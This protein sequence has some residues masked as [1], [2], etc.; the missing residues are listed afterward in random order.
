VRATASWP[1]L[2]IS[3]RLTGKERGGPIRFRYP[4]TPPAPRYRIA[5][6]ALAAVA[7]ALAA[8]CA[9]AAAAL[10]ARELTRRAVLR[11]QPRPSPLELAIAYVRDSQARAEP[12]R[13]RALELLSEAAEGRV[14]ADAADRAWSEPPPT[15]AGAAELAGL[16]PSTA[17]EL[18]DVLAGR[19]PGRTSDTE[20]TVYKAMGHV[21]EDAAAAELAYRAAVDAGLGIEVAL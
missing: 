7:I 9:L 17:T 1:A 11:P 20:I 5:P 19:A 14:A 6:A 13:R 12:D 18:G 10:V 15:P 3:S 4:A 16:D 8:L 2:R 21:A